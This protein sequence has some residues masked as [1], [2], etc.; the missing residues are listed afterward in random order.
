[1][2]P[3]AS[4][5]TLL[6]YK[7][8]HALASRTALPPPPCLQTTLFCLY[9]DIP[10]TLL[11]CCYLYSL[12]LRY[13]TPHIPYPYLV[14]VPHS[15]LIPHTSSLTTHTSPH[16]ASLLLPLPPPP[17]PPPPPVSLVARLT[18]PALDLPTK[19]TA[20]PP[21]TAPHPALRRPPPF[22]SA[23]VNRSAVCPSHRRAA[24]RVTAPARLCP[25][26]PLGPPAPAPHPT[27]A[28]HHVHAD[29]PHVRLRPRRLRKGPLCRL[30]VFEL[31][32][33]QG[34]ERQARRKVRSLR[35]LAGTRMLHRRTPWLHTSHSDTHLLAR[36]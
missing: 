4:T 26:L 19:A 12:L 25:P 13:L 36:F 35:S 30:A 22:S 33:E 29:S 17:P 5:K 9:R 11:C 24:N 1:M 31:R 34:Q 28:R 7:T 32:R 23:A 15:Y 8:P 27:T 3:S 10:A 6:C 2:L 21:I 18:S 16:L 14:H 20:S